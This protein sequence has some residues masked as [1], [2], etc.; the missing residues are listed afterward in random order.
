MLAKGKLFSPPS[1]SYP[2]PLHHGSH[3]SGTYSLLLPDRCEMIGCADLY[4]PHTRTQSLLIDTTKNGIS[5]E[6]TTKMSKIAV[7]SFHSSAIF[8]NTVDIV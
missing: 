7:F 1:P 3:P 6:K 2:Y 5:V 8:L 4:V